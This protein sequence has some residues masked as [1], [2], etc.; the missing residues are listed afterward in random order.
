MEATLLMR[1]ETTGETLTV[2]QDDPDIQFLIK[3]IRP[4]D[5]RF[6][7]VNAAETPRGGPRVGPDG[8]AGIICSITA[9]PDR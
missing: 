5:S 8:R 1:A 6:C 3:T 2:I 4:M 9:W 7:L